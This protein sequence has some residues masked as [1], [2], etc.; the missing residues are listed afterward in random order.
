MFLYFL[1]RITLKQLIRAI[2]NGLIQIISTFPTDNDGYTIK[3]DL[4][5]VNNLRENFEKII[6]SDTLLLLEFIVLQLYALIEIF[7]SIP[8][9]ALLSSSNDGSN[10]FSLIH[11]WLHEEC[12]SDNDC[13]KMTQPPTLSSAPS[14]SSIGQQQFNP[15]TV[16]TTADQMHVLSNELDLRALIDQIIEFCLTFIEVLYTQ[17]LKSYE[18]TSASC[19]TN[20]GFCFFVFVDFMYISLYQMLIFS[21]IICY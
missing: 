3:T 21:I 8:S 15:K 2:I 14:S 11:L 18:L 17:L 7:G 6:H 13:R 10:S 1:F 9:S 20:V 16:T 5:G 12:S 4:Y 19:S